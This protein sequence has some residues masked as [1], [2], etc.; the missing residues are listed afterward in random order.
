MLSLDEQ[1]A[2]KRLVCP[3]TRMP[4]QRDGDSLVTIGGERR[5]PVV[6]GVPFLLAAPQAYEDY[7]DAADSAVYE[8]DAG[9]NLAPGAKRFVHRLL[10][11]GGDHRTAASREAFH[12]AIAEQPPGAICLSIGGGP[13][14]PHPALVNMN[15]GPF[16]NV[17]LVGDANALPY[18][19]DS[20]EAIYCEAVL[21]H[22]ERPDMAVTE[23]A[24]V[25]RNGGLVFA[26]TPFLQRYHGH[27]DHYQNFTLTGH[28]RLFERAGF[29]IEATGTCVGPVCALSAL[30]GSF[31]RE[32]IPT[33]LLSRIA[34]LLVGLAALPLRWL[35][36]V[37]PPTRSHI[38]ASS[39]FVLARNS[40][41]RPL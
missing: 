29:E 30:A 32:F 12:T 5:Y 21:E 9:V 36:R 31:A 37:L 22:L 19:N 7:R 10:A 27:P 3:V 16:E 13:S 2:T 26:A 15:I 11:L 41:P 1:V 4:L 35:D 38:L 40:S 39:T 25:L 20:I 33:R 6:N 14:R 34:W 24:R 8:T 23:M 18:A 17:D 28:R